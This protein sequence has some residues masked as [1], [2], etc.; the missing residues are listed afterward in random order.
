MEGSKPFH[1]FSSL[2]P[3]E[4]RK[5]TYAKPQLRDGKAIAPQEATVG[6]LTTASGGPAGITKAQRKNMRRSLKRRQN[7][8]E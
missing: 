3:E 2:A 1:A 5:A 7:R 4:R 6:D 8:I